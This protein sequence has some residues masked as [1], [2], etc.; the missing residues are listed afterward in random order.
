MCEKEFF[1]IVANFQIS[2]EISSLGKKVFQM[3]E[4]FLVKVL[5]CDI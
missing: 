1:A 2:I 5:F 3:F 4:G